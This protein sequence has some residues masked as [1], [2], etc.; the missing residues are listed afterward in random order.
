M[1]RVCANL[2]VKEMN[3]PETRCYSLLQETIDALSGDVVPWMLWAVQRSD[4][5][6]SIRV[7]VKR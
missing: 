1:S 7:A 4:L 5:E 3:K 6:L 2:L